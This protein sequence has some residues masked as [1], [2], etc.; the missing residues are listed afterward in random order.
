MVAY[1]TA[2][3]GS[4]SAHRPIGTAGLVLCMRAE[5]VH[6]ERTGIH[7]KVFILQGER[8]LTYSV[9]NVDRSEDRIRL[10]NHAHKLLAPSLNGTAQLYTAGFLQD[11]LQG[12][13]AGLWDAHI[14]AQ[15][16]PEWMA[17]N[18]EPELPT[19]ALRPYIISGGGTI[20][21]APPG[22]GKSYTGQLWAVSMDA[23]VDTYWLVKQQRVLHVNLERARRGMENRL[24]NVNR[25]LGLDARRPL[26][27]LNARGRNLKDM[28]PGIRKAIKVERVEH[29]MLDSISRA[30]LGDL[31]ENVSV[32]GIMDA[33]NGLAVDSWSA[34]GH[35]SRADES[36]IYGGIHFDAAADIEVRLLTQQ[37]EGQS[38]LG[39]GL[40]LYKENDVGKPATQI[41][42]YEFLP[43]GLSLVRRARVGEFPEIEKGRKPMMRGVVE[44]YL[45]HVG[46]A[47]ATEIAAE[48]GYSRQ[49]IS[50]LLSGGDTFQMLGK[51]GRN[52]L[53][54]VAGRPQN[55]SRTLRE[56][57]R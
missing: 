14:G 29:V 45:L 9:L 52:V 57:D 16:L 20:L 35:T 11:D 24:G 15:P 27:T 21:F 26:L 22:R 1:E 41:L 7:A 49:K 56:S 37:S 23:G 33:L 2:E 40:Q 4:L 38:T 17:G 50:E 19:F 8:L 25:V 18:A 34:L 32:N 39:I 48:T 3:D 13:C 53:Y 30:G 31:N 5:Q 36:H 55:V 42:A 47:S 51:E 12:F 46:R 10:A 54:G 28:L 43:T 44:Q 6:E